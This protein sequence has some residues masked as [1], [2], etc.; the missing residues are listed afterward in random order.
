M[1]VGNVEYVRGSD[2]ATVDRSL[3][4]AFD[5]GKLDAGLVPE[6]GSTAVGEYSPATV[7]VTGQ[8]G[9]HDALVSGKFTSDFDPGSPGVQFVRIPDAATSS[10]LSAAA[11]A[12]T[13][14]EGSGDSAPTEQLSPAATHMPTLSGGHQQ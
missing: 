4:A 9:L 14:E 2:V 8:S 12:G 11:A 6:Q 1:V 13:L 10:G 7:V 3:S 5:T